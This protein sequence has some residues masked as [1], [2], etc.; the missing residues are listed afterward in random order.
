MARR[1]Q[2]DRRGLAWRLVGQPLT[3][4]VK[5]IV[6]LGFLVICWPIALIS[7]LVPK[8]FDIGL[9]PEPLINNIYHKRAL[10]SHGYTAE[11]FVDQVWFITSDFDYRGDLKFGGLLALIRPYA[12][13]VR[14][15]FRYRC[16]YIYFN[17]GPLMSAPLAWRAEPSLLRVAGVRVVVMPYGGD[18]QVMSRSKN[19]PFRHAKAVDYPESRFRERR[20]EQQID[21]WTTHADHVISGVEWV[22]YMYFWDTLMLG[23]FSIDPDSWESAATPRPVDGTLRIF[24]APNHRAIKGS[25]HFIRAVEE[26]RAEGVDVELVMRE[27]V[28]NEV[29]RQTMGEVDAVADQLIVGWYAMFA[30][31]AMAMGKPVL[32]YLR[33]DLLDLYEAE[34]L[35]GHGEMPILNCDPLSVKETI[36]SLAAD[37]S[38]LAGIAERGKAYVRKHHSIEAIGG[39]FDRIN[40]EVGIA[41]SKQRA[42]AH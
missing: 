42:D 41:P 34:G 7:R 17:G 30:L 32:C 28:P 26:L 40:R 12:L 10:E 15:L 22:D 5:W 13:C 37:R 38:Q 24:H 35:L 1:A 20:V 39:V 14:A 29:I 2:D 16:L 11:T 27:R 33:K 3:R 18:V 36:R 6:A 8:R 4:T 21:L 25:D 23:H 31:E 19:L 9:G